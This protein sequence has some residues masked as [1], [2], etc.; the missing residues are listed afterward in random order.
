MLVNLMLKVSSVLWWVPGL[1][2]VQDPVI[3]QNI[4]SYLDREQQRVSKVHGS[5]KTSLKDVLCS[6]EFFI[7]NVCLSNIVYLL[8]SRHFICTGLLSVVLYGP[9]CMTLCADLVV[10]SSDGP[11]SILSLCV[12]LVIVVHLTWTMLLL[13][14]AQTLLLS[15]TQH[16]PLCM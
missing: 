16:G 6:V 13:V 10:R 4:P 14:T 1:W 9:C 12:D 8:P 3:W 5:V 2:P 15:V 11:F 7:S